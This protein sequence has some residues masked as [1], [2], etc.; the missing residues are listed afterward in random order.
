MI[1]KKSMGSASIREEERDKGRETGTRVREKERGLIHFLVVDTEN[2]SVS[3]HDTPSV[4]KRI[5]HLS[6]AV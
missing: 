1:H 3:K 4:L 6:S 5:Y 2:I